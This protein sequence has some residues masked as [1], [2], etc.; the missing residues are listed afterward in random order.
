MEMRSEERA[1]DKIFRRRDRYDI[2]E[3]QRQEVW[4]REKKQR[5]IDSILRGWN[6]AADYAINPL[7]LDAG[8]DLPEGVLVDH[9][10]D[11][12]SCGWHF[13]TAKMLCSGRR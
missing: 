13:L 3:W 9:Q 5:L 10:A 8:L 12:N 4:T 1:I 7:L 2:P 11:Q 6:E